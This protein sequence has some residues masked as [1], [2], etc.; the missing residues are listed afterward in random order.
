M[1]EPDNER[2][3]NPEDLGAAGVVADVSDMFREDPPEPV[4]DD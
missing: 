4:E 2:D 3:D 1:D